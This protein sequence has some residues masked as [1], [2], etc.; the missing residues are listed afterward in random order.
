MWK[1]LSICGKFCNSPINLTC[2]LMYVICTQPFQCTRPEA[3][4]GAPPRAWN[5]G[6]NKEIFMHSKHGKVLLCIV[7]SLLICAGAWAQVGNQA[8]LEGTVT[9]SSGAVVPNATVKLTNTGTA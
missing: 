1:T 3:A 8:S 7:A 6:E 5:R 2:Y 9:D 4:C